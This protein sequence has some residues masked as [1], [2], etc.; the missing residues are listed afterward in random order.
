[1]ER[2]KAIVW[3]IEAVDFTQAPGEE[4]VAN[5]AIGTRR[6]RGVEEEAGVGDDHDR[7]VR[8]HGATAQFRPAHDEC[9]QEGEHPLGAVYEYPRWLKGD[10]LIEGQLG[11]VQRPP[12]RPHGDRHVHRYERRQQQRRCDV[13][14][15]LA[16]SRSESA[17][18]PPVCICGA[19]QRVQYRRVRH[20]HDRREQRSGRIARGADSEQTRLRH[21]PSGE[22]QERERDRERRT[23]PTLRHLETAAAASHDASSA[24]SSATAHPNARGREVC[25][26]AR[27]VVRRPTVEACRA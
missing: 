27:T 7:Q 3:R 23:K 1:M 26:Y 21:Q 8:Q 24:A 19:D 16:Q 2:R 15:G 12:R 4:V 6:E 22:L 11:S 25:E 18:F 10:G 13:R 14:V 17:S 20:A 9:R 5:Y